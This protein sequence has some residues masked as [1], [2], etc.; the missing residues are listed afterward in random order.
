VDELSA[1][2]PDRG[3]LFRRANPAIKVDLKPRG[4]LDAV[5]D[6]LDGREKPALFSP[7][8]TVAINLLVSDWQRAGAI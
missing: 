3:G 7:A 4:S 1:L 8:D 2:T 6:I 5:A